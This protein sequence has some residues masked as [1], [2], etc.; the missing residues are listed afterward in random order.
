M[1]NEE[2]FLIDPIKSSRSLS[3]IKASL[4][5]TGYQEINRTN[6]FTGPGSKERQIG[7]VLSLIELISG[8][9]DYKNPMGKKLFNN[10]GMPL[11]STD[12]RNRGIFFVIRHCYENDDCYYCAGL[13]LTGTPSRKEDGKEEMFFCFDDL[14]C[15]LF[16]ID[17][18]SLD[19]FLKENE[20]KEKELYGE[21]SSSDTGTWNWAGASSLKCLMNKT[22]D[23]EDVSDDPIYASNLIS[24]IIA[25]IQDRVL[26]K[27]VN[28]ILGVYILPNTE[29]DFKKL[30]G[31]K[32]TE[33]SHRPE[34][35]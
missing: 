28:K 26:D 8:F 19:S 3:D 17:E 33:F 31:L 5:M 15:N 16:R 35:Y 10:N 27:D 9:Y 13:S 29:E 21:N 32:W 2:I 22:M 11:T 25:V 20:T 14:Y 30:T 6:F 24:W 34:N 7:F 18:E 1:I 12:F 4:E 23:F